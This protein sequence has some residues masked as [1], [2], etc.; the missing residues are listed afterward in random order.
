MTNKMWWLVWAAVAATA[1]MMGPHGRMMGVLPKA[2]ESKTNPLTPEK[3]E[4]GRMLFYETRISKS[5]KLSCNSC[6]ALDRYGVDGERVSVGHNGQRGTRN[7][8]TVYHAAGHIAQFWDGRVV[9]V[10]EQAAGPMMNPVEMAMGSAEEAEKVLRSL[11]G[12]REAFGKAFPG[13]AEPVTLANAAKAIGAFERTLVTPSRWDRFLEGDRTAIT[14]QERR[15]HH[16]F[17]HTGCASCHNGVY[18]GGRM[19]QKLGVERPWPDQTDVG[20]MA[21]TKAR[22]D[23][24]VFKVPSLRNVEKTGPYF[25]NGS[26]ARLE[27]AVRLMARHQLNVELSGAETAD[28]VAW[29]KTLTGEL[30]QDHLRKPKLPAE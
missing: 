2:I 28:V 8:P 22:S 30:R 16:T 20:R 24:M 17:M 21:V 25:H 10:E 12:Y 7:S 15:G 26:A 19:F 9:D 27:E 4:L 23:E 1:Q 18:V 13:E 5:G 29:L 11:R 6:H 14:E 3:V